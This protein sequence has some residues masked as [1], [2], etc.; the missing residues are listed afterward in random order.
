MIN[1]LFV[2]P[3]LYLNML[4]TEEVLQFWYKKILDV[5][6]TSFQ[7]KRLN[8]PWTTKTVNEHL[9]YPT[10]ARSLVDV[11]RNKQE[12]R[13]VLK[14]LFNNRS[15]NGACCLP[16]SPRLRYVHTETSSIFYD[17]AASFNPRSSIF[18]VHV[19][20]CVCVCEIQCAQRR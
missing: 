20:V 3:G 1:S 6:G 15:T 7:C 4:K 19:C 5:R 2:L 17:F 8:S 14:T 13:R 11:C 16:P 9:K 10:N 12:Y 18:S